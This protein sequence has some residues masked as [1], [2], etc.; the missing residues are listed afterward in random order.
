MVS[1]C[2]VPYNGCL[3]LAHPIIFIDKKQ[4][5]T[6]QVHGKLLL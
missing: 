4:V 3:H 1:V 6:T 2:A 5:F